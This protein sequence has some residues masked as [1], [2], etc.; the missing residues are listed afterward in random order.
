MNISSDM[1]TVIIEAA[2]FGG[3]EYLNGSNFLQLNTFKNISGGIYTAYIRDLEDCGTDSEEFPHIVLP[4]FITPN[5][6]G[7]KDR[8]ELKGVEFLV[9]QK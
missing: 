2:N 9:I 3:F 5:N 1:T 4:K 7:I 8:F 6:D